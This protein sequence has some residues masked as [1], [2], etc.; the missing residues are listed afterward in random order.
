MSRPPQYPCFDSHA[1]YGLAVKGLSVNGTTYPVAITT[2]GAV[3]EPNVRSGAS[4]SKLHATV[5][6][7]GL[8]PLKAYTVYRYD[9]VDSLPVGPPFDV[10]YTHATSFRALGKTHKFD[11]ATPF[12]SD[13]AVYYVAVANASVVAQ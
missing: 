11:D 2:D 9:G 6:V 7:S 4:P 5:H 12:S 3:K 13:S 10:G 1:T 8:S